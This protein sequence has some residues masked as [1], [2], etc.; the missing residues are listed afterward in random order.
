MVGL[1]ISKREALIAAYKEK[2]IYEYYIRVK[3]EEDPNTPRAADYDSKRGWE[4]VVY[5]W[6]CAMKKAALWQ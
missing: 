6:K 5:A 3:R 1:R 4:S 2:Y